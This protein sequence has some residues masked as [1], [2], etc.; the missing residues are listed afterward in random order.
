[1]PTDQQG[2]GIY[3]IVFL[4]PKR[5]EDIQVILDV[6]W[7]NC[8]IIKKKFWMET[9][10]S[11]LASIQKGGLLASIDLSEVYLHIAILETHQR[12]P[13]FAYNSSNFLCC[14]LPLWPK[15]PPPSLHQDPGGSDILIKAP[16]HC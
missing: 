4:V 5:K 10:K 13:R 2:S 16:S 14:A 12:S 6:K 11:I 3:S 7:L 8:R 15:N 1:M 9:L